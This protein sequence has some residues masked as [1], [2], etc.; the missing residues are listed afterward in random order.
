VQALKDVSAALNGKQSSPVRFSTDPVDV[1]DEQ[2]AAALQRF[3]NEKGRA[4]KSALGALWASGKDER[5]PD[6]AL[7]RQVRNQFGPQ[8]LNSKA[9]TTTPQP[10]NATTKPAASTEQDWFAA[11]VKQAEAEAKK[12]PQAPAPSRGGLSL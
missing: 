8:W 4:W 12:A 7:L 11:S 9:N 6:G 1:P 10:D 3:A 5:H 2:Q